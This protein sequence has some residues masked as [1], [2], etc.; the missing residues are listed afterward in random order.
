MA[1]RQ[2]EYLLSVNI[3]NE[4]AKADQ[5]SAIALLLIRLILLEPGSDPLHP[6]MG[7]GIRKYRYALNQLEELQARIEDQIATYLP[8]YQNATVALI[9]TPDKL[10]NIEITIDD[11]TYVYDSSIA[12]IPISLEDVQSR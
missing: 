9:R 7:V 10:C 1:V 12:P 11:V 6:M 2:R 4:P 5:Q 3:Y 8:E